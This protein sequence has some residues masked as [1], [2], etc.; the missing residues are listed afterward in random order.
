M[1]YVNWISNYLLGV[2]FLAT[3]GTVGLSHANSYFPDFDKRI[4]R[5]PRNI[6]SKCGNDFVFDY[7]GATSEIN[8]QQLSRLMKQIN[9]GH[10]V[11]LSSKD[12]SKVYT[13][14]IK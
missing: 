9:I 3:G 10:N 5:F 6:N 7:L 2:V 12:C 13:Y 8:R 1:Q 11:S 14:L 4:E